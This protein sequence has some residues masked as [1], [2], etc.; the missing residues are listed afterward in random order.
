MKRISVLGVMIL[1]L[2]FSIAGCKEKSQL[3]AAPH[4]HDSV[5]L[6]KYKEAETLKTLLEKDPD[7]VRA[8]IRLGNIYF[9]T[10]QNEDAVNAYRKALVLN[11]KN[12]DVRTDMGICLRRLK[13]ADEAIE[14]F[15]EAID[16]NPR[17]YQSRYNLGLVLLHEKNDLQGAIDAWEGLLKSVPEFPGRDKLA[18]QVEKLKQVQP[19]TGDEEKK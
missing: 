6:N 1:I 3:P 16:A 18:L 14:A 8:L 13:R 4:T 9:D 5:D 7:N 12:A 17:H 2:I 10:G 11:P 19:M 15:K